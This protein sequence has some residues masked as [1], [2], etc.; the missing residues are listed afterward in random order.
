MEKFVLIFNFIHAQHSRIFPLESYLIDETT[1]ISKIERV[2]KKSLVEEG[3]ML[4]NSNYLRS[5]CAL[6]VDG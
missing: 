1:N 6:K 4:S 3:K 2:D 5:Q